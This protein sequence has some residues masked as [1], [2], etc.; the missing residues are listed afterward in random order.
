MY[1]IAETEESAE[2]P[3]RSPLSPLTDTRDDRAANGVSSPS[4]PHDNGRDT[5][6]PSHSILGWMRGKVTKSKSDSLNLLDAL[7]DYIDES[8]NGGRSVARTAQEHALIANILSLR[9]M[10]VV[11]VMIPRVDIAAIDINAP[12]KDLLSLLAEKQYSRLPVYRENLDDV[13]GV[14]HIKDI[15]ASL[16]QGRDIR[17]D[18]LVRDVPIV[19]PAMPVFDLILMMKQQRRHMAMVVDEYGGIDGLVTIGDVIEAIIGSVEDEYD[20]YEEPQIVAAAD[21]A[22]LADGRLDIDA[23]EEKCGRLLTEDEREDIDTLGGLIFSIAGRIPARGE[24]LTHESGIVFEI[25]EADPRRVNKVLIRN[26]P[27]P[28]QES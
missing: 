7:E 2:P 10:T 18:K 27:P 4:F 20:N 5:P 11:D 13:V 25:V 14:I 6:E 24:V 8:R 9:D 19:S 17:I 28:T 23:F 12:D 21:G 15:L 16:S 1:K 22:L 26:L 3:S